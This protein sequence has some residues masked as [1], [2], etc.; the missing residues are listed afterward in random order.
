MTFKKGCGRSQSITVHFSSHGTTRLSW[1]PE[2]WSFLPSLYYLLIQGEEFSGQE[3][4]TWTHA[5]QR[6]EEL[7]TAHWRVGKHQRSLETLT[8]STETRWFKRESDLVISLKF[9]LRGR[10]EELWRLHTQVN[11]VFIWKRKGPTKKS[12]SWKEHRCL[13]CLRKKKKNHKVF[14]FW[15]II[16]LSSFSTGKAWSYLKTFDHPIQ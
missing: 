2:E 7:E 13:C 9:L 10:H 12:T 5:F 6:A 16:Y 1:S 15:E 4:H 8:R 14:L 3:L 11:Y